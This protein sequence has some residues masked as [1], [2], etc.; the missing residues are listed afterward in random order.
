[1]AR[2]QHVKALCAQIDELRDDRRIDKSSD[3]I[4]FCTWEQPWHPI[5]LEWKVELL[6][7][8]RTGQS[9]SEDYPSDHIT[10]QYTLPVNG[11]ELAPTDATRT[12][13]S[14]GKIYQGSSILMPLARRRHD[15][16]LRGYVVE[17]CGCSHE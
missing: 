13:A 7:I 9:G 8:R 14:P 12:E 6:A 10:G 5:L 2:V 17:H 4:G 16:A 3:R 11:V 15:E 1:S